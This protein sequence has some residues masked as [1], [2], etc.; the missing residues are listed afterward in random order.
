MRLETA[1]AVSSAAITAAPPSDRE[2]GRSIGRTIVWVLARV[3][4]F[5]AAGLLMALM[6]TL[7]AQVLDRPA[8]APRI[9]E[10]TSPAVTADNPWCATLNGRTICVG[11]PN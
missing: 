9:V 1:G 3:W 5:A 6:A 8:A 7:A 2:A 10:E 11:E 4:G